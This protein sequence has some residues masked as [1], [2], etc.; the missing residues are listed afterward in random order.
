MFTEL[1]NFI[2][3]IFIV[4]VQSI[5]GI[6]VL[7]L[8]TPILLL[9]DMSMIDIMNYLLPISIITSLFNLVIMKFKDNTF[10]YDVARLKNFFI[11]CVPFVFIGLITLRYLHNYINFDYL[12]SLTIILTLIF[13]SKLSKYLKSLSHNLNKII[14]MIIGIIHGVTNSGGTLLSIM[15][16]NLNATKKNSRNEITLF[17]FILALI[18][19]ILFYSVFGIKL[20][21]Y[22]F[23]LIIIY[24]LIGVFLGNFLLNFT[25]DFLYKKLIYLLA[26]I[27]S[28]LLIF[29]N[30]I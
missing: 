13:R 21:F 3:I 22:D 28:I 8:G 29:K 26:F 7:V 11:I 16:V 2:L 6:G 25:G 10:Y 24:T 12:V 5:L 15:L 17:Y 9:L 20:S 23:D 19:L 30:I 27:T 14:L 4:A 18:Q 1:V